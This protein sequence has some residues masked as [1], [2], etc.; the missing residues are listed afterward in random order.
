MKINQELPV[1]LGKL[2]KE[3]TG[4]TGG[5]L[6]FTGMIQKQDQK[7]HLSSLNKLLSDIEGAG[8]RLSRSRNFKDLSK[9]KALVKRFLKE[10]VDYGMNLKQSQSW[11]Q[12][13]QTRPL[14]TVELIDEKLVQLTEEIMNT[15]NEGLDLLERI[16]EIKG[17]LIN[18]YT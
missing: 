1:K 11:D 8:N 12:Y 2:T 5:N 6:P 14:K 3:Q 7:M 15:E 18:L 4:R 9:Y 13:G 16:G 10:T 17:L